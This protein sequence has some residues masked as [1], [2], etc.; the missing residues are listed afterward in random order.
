MRWREISEHSGDDRYC[1]HVG[2]DLFIVVPTKADNGANTQ[3]TQGGLC[4][5]ICAFVCAR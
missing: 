1:S 5:L 2:A 3:E 4:G